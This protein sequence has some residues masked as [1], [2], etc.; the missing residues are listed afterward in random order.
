MIALSAFEFH[1]SKGIHFSNH[2]YWRMPCGI[3]GQIKST[4][5]AGEVLI[6]KIARVSV[7]HGNMWKAWKHESI[8]NK[9]TTKNRGT[10]ET[11][12]QLWLCC[13]VR[14][15]TLWGP[16]ITT[17]K[18][19]KMSRMWRFECFSFYSNFLRPHSHD[20]ILQRKALKFQVSSFRCLFRCFNMF[21]TS[22]IFEEIPSSHG[23]S[24]I[25]GKAPFAPRRRKMLSEKSCSQRKLRKP[26]THITRRFE[27]RQS[28][29]LTNTS[30]DKSQIPPRKK[31]ATLR[32]QAEEA[33]PA[34]FSVQP[35][36]DVLV[37]SSNRLVQLL[38]CSCLTN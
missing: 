1:E 33:F 35:P 18:I 22:E 21:Q 15:V 29:I 14:L 6:M 16:R 24:S 31:S 8:A 2:R 26:R 30:F 12:A 32:H 7:I 5:T 38:W 4:N 10:F 34:I 28:K 9:K 11:W 37:S 17:E 23:K 25:F 36:R 19:K 13:L 3:K 27:K 20:S